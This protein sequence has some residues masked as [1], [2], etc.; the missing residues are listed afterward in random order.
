MIL[1]P[2]PIAL[3]AG[4]TLGAGL[5]LRA[6]WHG[7]AILRHW[8][9]R[10]GSSRQLALERRTS[11]IST[12][13]AFALS[14][15]LLSL[16]LFV[17]TADALAPRFTGAMC[18]VGT[19]AANGWGHPA[20]AARL[21]GALLAGLW[22]I[23]NHADGLG[24]DHP[25]IRPRHAFLLALL[26]PLL[27]ESWLQAEFF[28]RLEPEVITSCCGRLFSRAGAGPGALLARV[29]EPL[30]ATALWVT[31]G[32]A[33]AAGLVLS[34]WPARGAALALGAAAALAGPCGLLGVIAWVSPR[35]YELPSHRCPFCLLQAEYRWVGYPLYGALFA[36]TVAG[37]GAGM[38][39]LARGHESLAVALPG[40]QRRLAR[41]AA[42]LFALFAAGAAALVAASGLRA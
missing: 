38:L 22:L 30:A 19:F 31:S 40:L 26:P 13:V 34:R 8:D 7:V 14:V 32:A 41:V 1:E 20:L 37:V 3:V 24:P 17:R 42:A 27:A 12:L 4:S 36:G 6:A 2:G 33:V 16:P 11:L 39:A 10:S 18:A 15:E 23:L 9:L 35:V 28:L 25:L 5:L 21:L 29:P